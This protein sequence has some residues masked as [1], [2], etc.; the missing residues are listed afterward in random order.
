LARTIIGINQ[1]WGSDINESIY[2][3]HVIAAKS[4][5]LSVVTRVIIKKQGARCLASLLV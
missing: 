2:W 4:D 1:W 5:R 3:V